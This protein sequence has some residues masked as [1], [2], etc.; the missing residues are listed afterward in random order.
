MLYSKATD[1]ISFLWVR[2]THVLRTSIRMYNTFAMHCSRQ[3]TIWFQSSRT[4]SYLC[5]KSRVAFKQWKEANRPHSVPLFDNRKQCKRDVKSYFNK[6]TARI[7]RKRIH[8][9]ML[10]SNHPQP[11]RSSSKP[12]L[13]CSKLAHNGK[14]ITDTKELLDCWVNHFQS[15]GSSQCD[16]HASLPPIIK[17]GWSFNDW[18]LEGKRRYPGLWHLRWEGW[19]CPPSSQ[20]YSFG[21]PD[22]VSPE[23]VKFS[24]PQFKCWLSQICSHICQLERIPLSFKQGIVIP[25]H[26]GKGRDIRC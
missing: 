26:K 13:T 17:E 10:Q 7:E 19:T 18:I 21:G 11:F 1:D 16:N 12:K 9:E 24:G 23:H 6:C 15:L 4:L 3:G 20:M 14:V 8:D 5:W 2:I 22:N 25:V